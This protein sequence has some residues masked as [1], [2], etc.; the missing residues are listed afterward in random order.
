MVKNLWH[1]CV[2]IVLARCVSACANSGA[3]VQNDNRTLQKQEMT[4]NELSLSWKKRKDQGDRW[5]GV[6]R[7]YD[8]DKGITKVILPCRALR[9]RKI[10]QN[11]LRLSGQYASS[12]CA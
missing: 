6:R 4:G 1:I 12:P 11:P 8:P 5:A 10:A 3:Y 7:D 2:I 9:K